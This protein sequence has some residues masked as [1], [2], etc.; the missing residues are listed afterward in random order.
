MHRHSSVLLRRG[1]AMNY[2][3]RPVFYDNQKW[4]V[5]IID[6]HVA[7]IRR[8]DADG[9]TPVVWREGDP[10]TG[11]FVSIAARAAGNG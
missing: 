6:R 7:R 8:I 10:T 5:V 2:E 1:V 9:K 3:A 11:Q 4:L